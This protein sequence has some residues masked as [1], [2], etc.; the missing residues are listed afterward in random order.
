MSSDTTLPHPCCLLMSQ[1]VAMCRRSLGQILGQPMLWQPLLSLLCVAEPRPYILDVCPDLAAVPR[2][3]SAF[4][5]SHEAAHSQV[6][7][8]VTVPFCSVQFA[9]YAG[10]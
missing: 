2:R 5:A 7:A 1:N 8:P 6:E 3:A 4:R 10:R 9:R